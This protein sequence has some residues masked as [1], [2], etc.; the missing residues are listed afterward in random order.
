MWCDGLCSGDLCRGCHKQMAKTENKI[1]GAGRSFASFTRSS[2][3]LPGR[4]FPARWLRFRLRISI[5]QKTTG[6]RGYIG[7]LFVAGYAGL[8]Y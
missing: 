2:G 7:P 8:L 3:S 1:Q 6:C 4:Y 5:M